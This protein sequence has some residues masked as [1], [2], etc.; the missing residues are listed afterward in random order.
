MQL[1][2]L[3]LYIERNYPL[4]QKVRNVRLLNAKTINSTNYI[5]ETSRGV[6]VLKTGQEK[7]YVWREKIGQIL[8]WCHQ[9]GAK[10]PEPV[11]RKDG[12]Y[13]D[14]TKGRY[15]MKFYAG[16]EFSGSDSQRKSVAKELALLHRALKTVRVQYDYQPH[17]EFYRH[18]TKQELQMIKK[19]AERRR[20]GDQI[21]KQTQKRLGF[22]EEVFH[23]HSRRKPHATQLIHY[24]VQ[25]GNV[26]F[27]NDKVAV[28]LDFEAMRKGNPLQELAFAAFRFALAEPASAR[29]V[30]KRVVRFCD[31]YGR[32][33]PFEETKYLFINATLERISYILR[34]RYFTGD[35]LW[36]EDLEKQIRF[37][38]RVIP[39]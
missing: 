20:E 29:E 17:K 25:P 35:T 16:E 31:S 2:E 13:A 21:D 18:L 37:L 7:E 39:I 38:Q 11:K 4:L 3:G 1:I 27:E 22:L 28:I 36:K 26:L 14:P 10:V 9:K 30:K 24:D 6:F 5:V 15:L 32:K 23:A 34:K 33:P 8:A 19:K 12:K